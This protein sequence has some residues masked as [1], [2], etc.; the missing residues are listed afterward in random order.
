M[1]KNIY[2]YICTRDVM[3]QITHILVWIVVLRAR[4]RYVLCTEEKKGLL[5]NKYK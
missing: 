4:V 2:I 3:V 1:C 5:S